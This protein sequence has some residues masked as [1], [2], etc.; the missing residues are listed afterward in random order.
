MAKDR[1]KST[2]KLIIYG[3]FISQ[4]QPDIITSIRQPE[5]I[6][7][8]IC[9]QKMPKQFNE[10]YIY[11]YLCVCVCVCV[12]VCALSCNYKKRNTFE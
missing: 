8:K 5:G 7:T 3:R 11:I 10:I 1:F 4:F 12:C 6:K 9:R 2:W